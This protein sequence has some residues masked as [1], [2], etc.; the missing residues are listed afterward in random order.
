MNGQ[1]TEVEVATGDDTR[2]GS[3][4]AS[5]GVLDTDVLPVQLVFLAGEKEVALRDLKQISPGY[6]FDLARPVDR[7]V[8]VRAN[9][10]R[11]G[12]GELVEIDRRVGVRMLK[13]EQ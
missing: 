3:D 8:E 2:Q 6:V 12:I 9:G 13:C 1:E 10:R 5:G 11:I 4:L 7:H